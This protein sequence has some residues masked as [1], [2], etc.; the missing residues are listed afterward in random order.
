MSVRESLDE[1]RVGCRLSSQW[2]HTVETLAS[3]FFTPCWQVACTS[4]VHSQLVLA[5][6]AGR[7]PCVLSQ[8]AATA[9]LVIGSLAMTTTR[10]W[11]RL[12]VHLDDTAASYGCCHRSPQTWVA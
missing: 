11:A 4:S 5:F 1:M 3:G 8:S 9:H 7:D 10:P 6:R 2:D 12:C